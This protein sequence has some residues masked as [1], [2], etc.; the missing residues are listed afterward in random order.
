M[1][2]ITMIGA[3][4]IV[5]A[6]RMISDVL[7]YPE[8]DGS[9]LAL[10]DID[11]HRLDLISRLAKQMVSHSGRRV[12]VVATEDRRDA[13]RGAD[14]VMNM[15]QVGGLDA[16]EKDIAIPRKYG[17]EQCVGDTLGPGGIFRA[18]RTWPVLRSIVHDIEELAPDAT[19]LNFSNPMAVNVWAMSR[20][21]T[22]RIVGL[23][24]NVNL[25]ARRPG[26]LDWRAVR[27]ARHLGGW[28]QPHGLVPPAPPPRTEHVHQTARGH[29]A[30][31]GLRRRSRALRPDAPFRL[32]RLRVER[33][34]VGISAVL[35]AAQNR[36]SHTA[37]IRAR[38]FLARH[39]AAPGAR[40]QA[41]GPLLPRRRSISRRSSVERCQLAARTWSSTCSGDLPPQRHTVTAGC[42]STQAMASSSSVWPRS[43]AQRLSGAVQANTRLNS[44][45]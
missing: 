23:C 10:M 14:Y 1:P 31:G 15:I 25:T 18:V 39:T 20:I 3:G 22:I 4:S 44:S 34:F 32:L 42:D 16:Y 26:R 7:S 35:L 27:A 21:S 6:K 13:L 37:L 30:T 11:P 29:E 12:Q 2:R 33:P 9:T 36:C 38:N 19:L 17:I 28:H 45:P 40:A 5:F 41:A 8:L 43:S 24:H